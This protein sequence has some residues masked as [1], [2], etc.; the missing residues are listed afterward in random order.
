MRPQ[1]I[2]NR[3][4]AHTRHTRAPTLRTMRRISTNSL[5]MN[6]HSIFVNHAW[7]EICRI[8]WVGFHSNAYIYWIELYQVRREQLSILHTIWD[9]VRSRIFAKYKNT[10][11]NILCDDEV[12]IQSG[13]SLT[14]SEDVF[15]F[16]S[17][18][19]LLVL[20]Y[21]K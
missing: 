11:W 19:L 12:G 2:E 20:L 14:P 15:K 13:R 6:S 18:Y 21:M 1:D 17:Y 9:G 7:Y 4:H 8:R 10:Y 5:T 3:T 16:D